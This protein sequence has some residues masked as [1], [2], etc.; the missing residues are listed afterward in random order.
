MSA[1]G[2]SLV[3]DVLVVCE[4]NRARSP[5]LARLLQREAERRGLGDRVVVAD[6]G[7]RARSGDPVLPS[8]LH[9]VRSLDLGLD[10]HA[11]TVF[12]PDPRHELVLTMTEDHRRTVLRRCPEALER[13]FT[14]REVVR[15]VGSSRWDPRWEGTAQVVAQLHRVRPLVAPARTRE[16]VADPA[17]GGRRLARAVVTELRET[18]PR[19]ARVLW[20][21]AVFPA[22]RQTSTVGR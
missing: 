13:T 9:A 14:V 19:L 10:D 8:V 2:S 15:L 3:R 20:G 18:A 22:V 21:P 6:A 16:D 7:L 4:A 12:E 11:A 5:V 1:D 17:E